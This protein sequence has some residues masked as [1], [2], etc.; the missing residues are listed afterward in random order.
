M[1]AKLGI[2][3]VV[4]IVLFVAVGFI[5]PGDYSV[6]RSATINAPAA[7]VHALV[8]ELRNWPKWMPWWDQDATIVTSFGDLTTGVGASQK[9]TGKDGEGEVV[10]TR[11]DPASGIAYDMVFTQ[12]DTRMPS[13][14]WVEYVAEGEATRVTWKMAGDIETPVIGGYLAAMMDGMMVGPLFQQGLDTLKAEVE[15]AQEGGATEPTSNG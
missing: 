15:K 1:L 2:A 3:V 4:L 10:F 11:C 9:W 12:G 6:E 8:G 5:I 14:A 7:Q 13:K